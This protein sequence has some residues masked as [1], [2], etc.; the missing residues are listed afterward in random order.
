MAGTDAAGLRILI[1]AGTLG[2]P[3]GAQRALSSILRACAQ[4]EVDVVARKVVGDLPHGPGAPRRV[5]GWR[6][7]RWVGSKST[8]GLNGGI[9]SVLN[10]LRARLFPAYDIH[11]RLYQ[12]VELNSAVRARVRLLVPSGNA[13]D[14][15]TGASFDYVAM[16]APDNAAFVPEGVATTLLPPPLYP[17]SDDARPPAVDLPTEFYLT[18]FNP[19]GPVKGSDDL[20]R[21]AGQT[22]LPIVWCHSDRGVVN[23][24]P[25]S[26]R[27]HPSVV[28]VP[29]PNEAELR[30]LYERCTAYLCFSK[31][32]GF[33]W[34][35]ADGLRHAPVVVS[36]D[37]G[38]LTH[39]GARDLT[40]VVRVGD[41]FDVD[42]SA[43]PTS[44]GPL[45]DRDLSFQ[46]PEAFRA[47]LVELLE[48]AP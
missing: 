32:E 48:G 40:G 23:H 9:A 24:V 1:S 5:W 16:Q 22:R 21:A 25:E 14:A 42:W 2:G 20:E 7:W 6:H 28:H 30:W 4:D 45:P 43:L 3:G 8:V 27:D 47:R 13:I 26:L 31:T 10:P 12:G 19:Y 39:P 38:I 41:D 15:S 18:A 37:I 17:L 11:I 44:R 46:S 34:S 36:R 29:D 33:G 35:I